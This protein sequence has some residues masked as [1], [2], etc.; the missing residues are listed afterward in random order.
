MRGRY[1]PLTAAYQQ[2]RL[3]KIDQAVAELGLPIT[4]RRVGGSNF[5]EVLSNNGLVARMG[6]CLWQLRAGRAIG[7]S[8]RDKAG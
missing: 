8:K 7:D 3:E 5:H 1:P 6:Y 4:V 2:L